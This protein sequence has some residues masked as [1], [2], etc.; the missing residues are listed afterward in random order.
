M[1]RSASHGGRAFTLIELLVVIAIIALLVGILLPALSEAKRASRKTICQSNLRQFGIAYQNYATD[2]K[3]RIASFTWGPGVHRAAD[4]GRAPVAADRQH[5]RAVRGI[6]DLLVGIVEQHDVRAA[7]DRGGALRV[8]R[9]IVVARIAGD[10]LHARFGYAVP[11]RHRALDLVHGRDGVAERIA[12]EEPA[13]EKQAQQLASDLERKDVELRYTINYKRDA[14][15]DYWQTR[16]DFEQT[17]SALAAREKMYEAKKAFQ[18]ADVVTAQRL[19]KE[20]FAKW[21]Q[22]IDEF[23]SIMDDDATTGDDLLEFVKDYRKVLN[24]LEGTLGDDFPL[25]DVIEKFDREQDFT[26]ELSARRQRQGLPADGAAPP[27]AQSQP[28]ETPAEHA[29]DDAAEQ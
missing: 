12:R 7:V 25:W 5:A 15:Y 3:D 21:R 22:V 4:R 8:R 6:A 23:P 13:K 17:P 9:A 2:F 20:G 19:Y 1:K 11:G 10:E 14:N 26:E 18:A 28:Q 16:A 24:Q 27:P 29:A